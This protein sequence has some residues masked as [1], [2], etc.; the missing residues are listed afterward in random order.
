MAKK[1][2]KNSLEQRRV[3]EMEDLITQSEAAELSG[4]SLESI[5]NLVRRGRLRSKEIFGKKLVYRSE[6]LAFEKEKP[7]PKAEK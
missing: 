7:G 2:A 1:K 5:N 3:D 6:V 4:R